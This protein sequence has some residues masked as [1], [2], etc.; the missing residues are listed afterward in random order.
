MSENTA[1]EFKGRED[2]SEPL[3]EMPRWSSGDSISNCLSQAS[4]GARAHAYTFGPDGRCAY[5]LGRDGRHPELV[6]SMVE[7]WAPA[8]DGVPA[9]RRGV[10]RPS[11]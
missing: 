4:T 6:G 7:M 11:G 5:N 1:V 8:D 9:A 10:F 3:T 2:C